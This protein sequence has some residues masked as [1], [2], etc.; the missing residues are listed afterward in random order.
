MSSKEFLEE[1]TKIQTNLLDFFEH[2]DN[3]ENKYQ[4]LK[5]YL[6]K[7]KYMKINL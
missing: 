5:K 1:M 7:L 2:D 6:M 4:D 3:N